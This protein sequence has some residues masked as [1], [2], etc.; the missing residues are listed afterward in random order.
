M[1]K[2]FTNLR[3]ARC[4]QREANWRFISDTANKLY[5]PSSRQI[6]QCKVIKLKSGAYTLAAGKVRL[7]N[8]S[9][10]WR[11]LGKFM[12]GRESELREIRQAVAAG[13]EITV[14]LTGRLHKKGK[15]VAA[16]VQVEVFTP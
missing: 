10:R 16:E 11:H 12:E 4:H 14:W 9:F 13:A 5:V 3:L 1:Q 6:L 2:Q 8:N 7:R 15:L